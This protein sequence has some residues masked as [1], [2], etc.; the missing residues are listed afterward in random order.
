[1]EGSE[2][3]FTTAP[4]YARQ[5][6][7]CCQTGRVLQ[8]WSNISERSASLPAQGYGSIKGGLHPLAH[9]QIWCHPKAPLTQKVEAYSGSLAPT[10]CQCQ[11]W[12][13]AR[14]LLTLVRICGRCSG[15]YYQQNLLSLTCRII[16][17]HSD[18]R[19]LLGMEWQGKWYVDTALPLGYVQ[20]LRYL[21]H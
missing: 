13:R 21:M 6:S 11:Q 3:A 8:L 15:H 16:L 12:H 7:I 20:P 1:M 14:T 9:Q 19:H 2:L 10:R 18:D 4:I 5:Q 17:V